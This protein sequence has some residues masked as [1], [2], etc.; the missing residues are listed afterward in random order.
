M[1]VTHGGHAGG[2]S[3]YLQDGRIH[4]T[5]NFLGAQITTISSDEPLHPDRAR[6]SW[7]SHRPDASKATS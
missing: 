3:L 5:Y 7:R 2:Y 6:S 4:W 1:I